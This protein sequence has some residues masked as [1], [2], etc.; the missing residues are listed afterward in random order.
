MSAYDDP[1]VKAFLDQFAGDG[2]PKIRESAMVIS[3]DTGTV[4]PKMCLEIGAAIL[5]DKPLILCVHKGEAVP[6]H[7]RRLAA[8]IV[9]VEEAETEASKERL[10]AAITSVMTEIKR[11]AQ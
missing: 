5:L 7:I 2:L 3:I 10:T 11:R 1:E 8:Q 6:Q 4:T 9:V